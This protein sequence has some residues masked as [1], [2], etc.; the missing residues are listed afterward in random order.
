M[1]GRV[2]C[3]YSQAQLEQL[4]G[5]QH[6]EYSKPHTTGYNLGPTSFLSTLTS[7]GLT[8]MYWGWP[9]YGLI[10]ARGD[11]ILVKKMLR[12]YISNRCA[13][14]VEGCFEWNDTRTPFKYCQ[15]NSLK[16]H[17]SSIPKE[18]DDSSSPKDEELG[19]RAIFLA[20]IYNEDNHVLILTTES[21]GKF[22]K[23]HHR[24]PIF[25]S[26]TEVERWVSQEGEVREKL[27]NVLDGQPKLSENI[28][29]VEVTRLVNRIKNNTKKNLMS[30]DEYKEF[31]LTKGGGIMGFFNIKGIDESKN[32]GSFKEEY[33]INKST[34]IDQPKNCIRDI[35]TTKNKGY[36]PPQFTQQ[37]EKRIKEYA[38]STELQQSKD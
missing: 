22:S 26:K 7:A 14:I 19:E 11:E 27:R 32:K 15:K 1:C 37:R 31:M 24:M 29:I 2:Y 8:S 21:F 35:E 3:T 16:P 28:Q 13:I 36:N 18:L 6:T 34:F 5:R 20:G 9:K 30:I 33:K 12:S 17:T 38:D 23:V 4:T 10:N 25:L